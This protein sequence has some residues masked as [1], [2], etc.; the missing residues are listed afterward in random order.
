MLHLRR[1]DPVLRDQDRTRLE[2]RAIDP[3]VLTVKRWNEHGERLLV[4]NFGDTPTAIGERWRVLFATRDTKELA[5]PARS[6]RIL[7]R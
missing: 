5:V 7:G 4:V 3:Y 2:A 1:T 6:A